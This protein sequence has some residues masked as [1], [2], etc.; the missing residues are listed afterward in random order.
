MAGH[1]TLIEDHQIIN[2]HSSS[3]TGIIKRAFISITKHK[4][5][6]YVGGILMTFQKNCYNESTMPIFNSVCSPQSTFLKNGFLTS[7]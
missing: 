7:F 3:D 6:F 1:G 5:V 4:Q 2:M